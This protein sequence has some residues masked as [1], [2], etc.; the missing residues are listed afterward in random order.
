MP[1]N[2]GERGLSEYL[3]TIFDKFELRVH[4]EYHYTQDGLWAKIEDG[5]VRVGLSDYLQ[6]TAGDVAFVEVVR[7]GSVV[8]RQT[9]FGTLE[10]AKTTVSLLSP[11]SGTID[12]V[13][14]IVSEKPELVNSDPYGEGWLVILAPRSLEDDLKALMNADQYFELMLKKLETEHKKLEA[15]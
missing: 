10:T 3:Q 14:G 12:Q 7:Q 15:R 13:N 2:G 9:E 8:E 1:L 4:K 6:R 11:I 5:R